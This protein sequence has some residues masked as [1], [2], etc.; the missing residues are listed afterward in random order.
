MGEL[1]MRFWLMFL[2]ALCAP[3]AAR[4]TTPFLWE[5]GAS[6]SGLFAPPVTLM[7]TELGSLASGAVA[8]SI[9][10][11]T[12]GVFSNADSAQVIWAPMMLTLGSTAGAINTGGNISCW[13]LQ[14]VDGTTFESVASAPPRAPDAVFPLPAIILSGPQSFLSQGLVRVPAL[15]FKLLCQNNSGQTLN[16]AGNTVVL[17]PTAVQY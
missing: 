2:I 16:A 11:G 5:P 3:P 1:T 4:A 12:S 8:V 10:G 15:R 9:V 7:S 13:F 17:V 6:N 14:T